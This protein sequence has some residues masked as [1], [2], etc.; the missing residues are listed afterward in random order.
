MR[1][2]IIAEPIQGAQVNAESLGVGVNDRRDGGGKDISGGNL[3][4][5][6]LVFVSFGEPG[7]ERAAGA[8]EIIDEALP[9]PLIV[10]DSPCV[11]AL[12]EPFPT[13]ARLAREAASLIA[14]PPEL[15][16]PISASVGRARDAAQPPP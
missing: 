8:L 9:E 4:R 1:L 15:D 11:D 3:R 14:Q 10:G 16:F 6:G 2:L 5:R 12:D 7:I 13:L